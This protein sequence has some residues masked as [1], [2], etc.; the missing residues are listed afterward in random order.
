MFSAREQAILKTI[1]V[2]PKTVDEIAKKVFKDEDV[3]DAGIKI[4]NG[5]YRIE[6]KCIVHKLDWFLEKTKREGKLT[7]FKRELVK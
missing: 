1:A 7:Y 3:L 2:K 4:R 5:L 6:E